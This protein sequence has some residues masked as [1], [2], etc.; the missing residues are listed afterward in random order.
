LVL[1]TVGTVTGKIANACANSEESYTIAPSLASSYVITAPAGTV[2]TS[3]SSL[4][5]TTNSLTTTDRTFT[6]KFNNLVFNS[7][8]NK[9]IAI[10]AVN[11]V[12]N[13]VA[14][15]ILK[16]TT[17]SCGPAARI[18]APKAVATVS[19]TE[20]YPNPVSNDFNI[21]VTAAKAGVLSIAIYSLDNN[22]VVS[23]RTVQLQEGVNTINENVSSLNKGIYIVQLVNSS[24]GEVITKKLVKN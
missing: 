22:L 17:I 24:N 7:K 3:P 16:L 4:S 1:P 21:D 15:K 8:D 18:A 10:K 19:A 6:V 9:T 11:Q 12:G 14:D 5:N 20:V 23:P 2:V 13:N